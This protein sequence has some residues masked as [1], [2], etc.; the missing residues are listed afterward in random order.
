MYCQLVYFISFIMVRKMY[1]S[2][3]RTCIIGV[4]A[5]PPPMI[6]QNLLFYKAFLILFNINQC[7]Q[8]I[9]IA[10]VD[11]GAIFKMCASENSIYLILI[12]NHHRES[13]TNI[14]KVETYN[15]NIIWPIVAFARFINKLF[16]KMAA[17]ENTIKIYNFACDW[18]IQANLVCQNIHFEGPEIQWRCFQVDRIFTFASSGLYYYL[19]K[20]ATNE[21]AW[22]IKYW[23]LRLTYQDQCRFLTHIIKV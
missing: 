4:R 6:L 17:T 2:Y 8:S 9:S 19:L 12:S 23:W 20:I 18:P 3:S 14:F 13:H 11:F 7:P 16:F 22:L 1:T 10:K 15:G 21:N 5:P